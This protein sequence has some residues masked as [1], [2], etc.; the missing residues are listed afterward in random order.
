[1]FNKITFQENTV[2]IAVVAA[3]LLCSL[4]G[5]PLHELLHHAESLLG[6]ETSEHLSENA[7]GVKSNASRSGH[8]CQGGSHPQDGNV[9]QSGTAADSHG[10]E[11]HGDDS[12]HSHDS[13]DCSVCHALCLSATTPNCTSACLRPDVC[14]GWHSIFSESFAASDLH[15]ADARGP[16]C[17]G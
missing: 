14:V 4:L 15:V 6:S 13:H 7:S 12:E 3:F 17:L 5:R 10:H 1:M 11:P 8:K 16:P 2:R 9:A